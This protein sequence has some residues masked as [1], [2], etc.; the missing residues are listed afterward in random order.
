MYQPLNKRIV[1]KRTGKNTVA[2]VGFAQTSRDLIPWDDGDTE[3]WGLNEAAIQDWFK[4]WTRWFQIHPEDNFSRK[5]NHNDPNHLQWLESAKDFPIYMQK[6]FDNIPMSVELPLDEII[7]KYGNYLTSS[8]AYMLTLA[9]LE[10]FERIE[11][12]GFELGTR[13]EYHYQKANAEYLIGL[14]RGLGFEI[15]IP[16]VSSLCKGKMYGYEDMTVVFRQ[17]LE[18]RLKAI[19]GSL[20]E[21]NNKAMSELGALEMVKKFHYE[22]PDNEDIKKLYEDQQTV[23]RMALAETNFT[24]GAREEVKGIIGMYDEF[25][26]VIGVAPTQDYTKSKKVSDEQ[27]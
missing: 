17:K 27:I 11:L 24:I 4:R 21:S 26:E 5:D 6:H 1:S 19:L 20:E 16:P 10:G 13:T 8:L 2:L 23:A 18:N 12:Y 15:Y 22:N 9:M 3:I 14:A 7:P 25:L